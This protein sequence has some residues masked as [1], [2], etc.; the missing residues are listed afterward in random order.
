M[1]SG[2][3]SICVYVWE[4]WVLVDVGNPREVHPHVSHGRTMTFG[5]SDHDNNKQLKC[6]YDTITITQEII[7]A[8]LH[9]HQELGFGD[10][11]SNHDH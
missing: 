3:C 7:V 10:H 11:E 2:N 8:H 5:S 9:H 1:V 4:N 6:S